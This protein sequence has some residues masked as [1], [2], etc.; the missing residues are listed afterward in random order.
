MKTFSF[1]LFL[2]GICVTGIAQNP[3]FNDSIRFDQDSIQ[4]SDLPIETTQE[5]SSRNLLENLSVSAMYTSNYIWR[6]YIFDYP[7]IQPSI[8]YTLGES[9]FSFN[10]WGSFF[11]MDDS[12]DIQIS[13][14]AYYSNGLGN[15]FVYTLG[16]IQ[17]LNPSKYMPRSSEFILNLGLPNLPLSPSLNNY[18]HYNK[19]ADLDAAITVYSLFALEH[20]FTLNNDK[21]LLVNSSLG[22]RFNSEIDTKEILRDFNF[23]LSMPFEGKRMTFILFSSYTYAFQ[24]EVNKQNN[25]QAGINFVL[26]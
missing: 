2:F 6:D 22:A 5:D 11:V 3:A 21:S 23:G 17:Y 18:V 20:S 16:L 15:N 19:N 8:D 26:N 1:I 13:P 4:S 14:S 9:G 24:L 7:A 12:S 25:F 10:L